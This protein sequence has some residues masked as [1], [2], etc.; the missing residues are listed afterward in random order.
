MREMKIGT[1][2]ENTERQP[3]ITAYLPN[4]RRETGLIH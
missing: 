3:Y 4:R 2:T 1:F